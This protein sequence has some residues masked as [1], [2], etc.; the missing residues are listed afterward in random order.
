MRGP[1]RR[2]RFFGFGQG[3]RLAVEENTLPD[4]DL[5]Q[6]R[7]RQARDAVE[8]RR[9]TCA[10]WAEDDCDS[11]G[12]GKSDVEREIAPGVGKAFM[13]LNCQSMPQT[14]ISGSVNSCGLRCHLARS[15]K[16][17]PLRT[18]RFTKENIRLHVRIISMA[19]PLQL[20]DWRHTP[21][22]ALQKKSRAAPVPSDWRRH[23]RA[24]EPYRRCR[25]KPSS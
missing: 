19:T 5:S 13:D 7:R 20:F 25:W 23:S 3:I 22:R 9:L 15:E 8:Q 18:K 12:E 10:R 17:D 24:L 21:R 1:E 16:L 4:H 14:G 2:I 11:T 6:V